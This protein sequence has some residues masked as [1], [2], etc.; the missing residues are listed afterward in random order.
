MWGRARSDAVR[1]EFFEP[2]CPAST[3]VQAGRHFKPGYLSEIEAL[4]DGA[5]T[6]LGVP[7]S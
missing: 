1:T 2:P 6:T 3:L 5:M 7:P 4:T